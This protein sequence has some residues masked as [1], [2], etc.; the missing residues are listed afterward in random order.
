MQMS[1]NAAEIMTQEQII[2]TQTSKTAKDVAFNVKDMVACSQRNEASEIENNLRMKNAKATWDCDAP[3]NIRCRW[4]YE[5]IQ[6]INQENCNDE[7]AGKN[8]EALITAARSTMRKLKLTQSN[9]EEFYAQLM[10][11]L[12]DAIIRAKQARDAISFEKAPTLMDGGSGISA[13]DVASASHALYGISEKA[14]KIGASVTAQVLNTNI[15]VV[16]HE[17]A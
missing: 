13:E 10:V 1:A 8:H 6:L 11:K 9:H 12:Q 17:H 15:I 14:Q 5:V 16:P 4:K 2:M 3:E 7:S